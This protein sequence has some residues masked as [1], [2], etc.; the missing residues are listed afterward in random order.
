MCV[1]KPRR[2]AVDD[3][4]GKRGGGGGGGEGGSFVVNRA[5]TGFAKIVLPYIILRF[6]VCTKHSS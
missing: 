3:V 4:D 2:R 5:D 6:A 1:G